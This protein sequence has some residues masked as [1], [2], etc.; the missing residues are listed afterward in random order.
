MM[1]LLPL[2]LL[3]QDPK[4]AADAP[5]SLLQRVQD[6]PAGVLTDVGLKA[7]AAL[8]IFVVGRMVARALRGALHRTLTKRGMDAMLT[9]FLS[10][11][12][13]TLTLTM[14]VIAAIGQLGVATTSF[15]AVLGAAGLAVGLALQGT[16]GNFAS[17][18]MIILFRP[19]KVGDFI[20]AGGT[21]GVVLSVKIFVTELKTGD[22]KLVIVPN[23][24]I[25]GGNITNYSAHETRRVDMVFGCGYGDD[26]RVVKKELE[27]IL[28]EDERVLEEPAPVVKV[29]E[30]GDSSIN[31]VVRPWVKSA[32]YWAVLWDTHEKVK[33]RFDEKGIEIPFPQ[34]DVHLHQAS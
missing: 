26:V 7:L 21:S 13:Y 19:F 23:G 22:N 34:R 33:L 31:F 14:V 9:S 4:T 6:D 16:L 27:Q 24:S 2:L 32:D 18:V 11:I 17:G 28:A 5:Q 30:L 12:V 29:S 25:M 20:E 8:A 1:S 3:A 10:S 15:V